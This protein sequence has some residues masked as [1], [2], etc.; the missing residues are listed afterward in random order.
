MPFMEVVL[1]LEIFYI[2]GL[3]ANPFVIIKSTNF[4]FSAV[5][6]PKKA[7]LIAISLSGLC[8]IQSSLVKSTSFIVVAPR[9][10]KCRLITVLQN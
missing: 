6:D 2:P 1:A 9:I 3:L 10:P 5:S 4:Y 8:D 7:P